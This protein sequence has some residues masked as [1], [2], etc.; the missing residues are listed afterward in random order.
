[1]NIANQKSCLREFRGTYERLFYQFFP[2]FADFPV[3]GSISLSFHRVA[4]ADSTSPSAIPLYDV[5]ASH[6]L[7]APTTLYVF[8]PF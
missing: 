4:R 5:V 2:I 3:S 6:I 7:S 8:P 1:M